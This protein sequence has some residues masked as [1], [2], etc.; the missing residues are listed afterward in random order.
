MSIQ[1]IMVAYTNQAS[2]N[3]IIKSSLLSVGELVAFHKST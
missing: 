3:V 2:N 1:T